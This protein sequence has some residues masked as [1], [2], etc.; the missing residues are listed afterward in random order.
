MFNKL[1]KLFSNESDSKQDKPIQNLELEKIELD[2]EN[3]PSDLSIFNLWIK[4]FKG[5]EWQRCKKQR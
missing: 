4:T 2:L 3:A 1:F 5:F